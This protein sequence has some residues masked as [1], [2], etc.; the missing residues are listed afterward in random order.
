MPRE[1]CHVI[2]PP[3]KN[4]LQR[5]PGRGR[6]QLAGALV[7]TPY[8]GQGR[9]ERAAGWVPVGP[10]RTR[11]SSGAA[12]C[13]SPAVDR[14]PHCRP[15]ATLLPTPSASALLVD[16]NGSVRSKRNL[17]LSS[18]NSKLKKKKII[19]KQQ[20]APWRHGCQSA[21]R[22]SRLHPA[23]QPPTCCSG[24]QKSIRSQSDRARRQ[25]KTSPRAGPESGFALKAVTC[26]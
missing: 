22:P 25:T 4:A 13:P 7:R 1:K 21:L 20:W 9:S 8:L 26:K 10:E 16:V 23:S 2:Y 6:A 15:S 11:P 3:E 12:G 19:P 24:G 18:V 14:A 17:F 5:S